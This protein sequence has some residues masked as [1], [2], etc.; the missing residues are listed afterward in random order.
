MINE[1][2]LLEKKAKL[3]N[4]KFIEEVTEAGAATVNLCWQCGTCTASCP[5]GQHTAFRIRKLIRRVQLGFKDEVLPTDDLWMCTTCYTCGERCPRGVKI[6]EIIYTLRNMAVKLGYIA[7]THKKAVTM[8]IKTGHTIPLD[9]KGKKIRK[10]LGLI[11]SPLT[12][13]SNFKAL[14][15]VQNILRYTGFDKIVG[16]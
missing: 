8:M 6:P 3:V 1:V 15:D 12:T 9:D 11:N 5:S 10:K 4:P 2:R 7:E 13:L 16:A 14:E